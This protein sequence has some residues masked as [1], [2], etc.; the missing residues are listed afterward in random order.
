MFNTI[1]AWY[2]KTF[3][4]FED[5]NHELHYDHAAEMNREEEMDALWDELI[6]S[7]AAYQMRFTT[8]ED[9]HQTTTDL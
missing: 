4:P 6:D 9:D 1:K 2:L 8:S 5:P 3:L 7:D